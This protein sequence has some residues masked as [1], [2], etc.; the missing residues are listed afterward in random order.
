MDKLAQDGDSEAAAKLIEEAGKAIDALTYDESKSLEENEKAAAEL[1]TKLE[2]DLA[3][4]RQK[5][6][7]DDKK[8]ESAT[9]ETTGEVTVTAA[10]AKKLSTGAII[11]I[12][13]AAA[14]VIG[15]GIWLVLKQRKTK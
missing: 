2:A 1:L 4:Q 15:A 5:D 3:A 10:P 8:D 7:K 11:G 14:A 9:T 6:G 12:A 13:A